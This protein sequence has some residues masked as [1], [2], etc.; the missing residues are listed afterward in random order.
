MLLLLSVA[1]LS[2]NPELLIVAVVVFSHVTSKAN[3]TYKDFMIN[4][5]HLYKKTKTK[6][7]VSLLYLLCVS[8]VSFS[9]LLE[10]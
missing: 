10:K 9:Y 6:M 8:R 2:H 1:T 3:L 7:L 5:R 4:P